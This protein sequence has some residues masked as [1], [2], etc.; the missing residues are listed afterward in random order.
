MQCSNLVRVD[1]IL[2]AKLNLILPK[3]TKSNVVLNF[4]AKR[5]VAHVYDSIVSGVV[6]QMWGG[7]GKRQEREVF[8]N[9]T[10]PW[11]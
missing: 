5:C 8:L 11:F 6:W 3:S 9:L 10:L 7:G 2:H 4:D 1:H